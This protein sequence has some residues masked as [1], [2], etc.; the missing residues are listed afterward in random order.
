MCRIPVN[1][2]MS[3]SPMRVL[4]NVLS[5]TKYIVLDLPILVSLMNEL[6]ALDIILACYFAVLG[7]AVKPEANEKP[8]P[9]KSK[10]ITLAN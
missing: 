2:E 9:S 6:I 10:N 7:T 1:P 4:K 8:E 5:P 3:S